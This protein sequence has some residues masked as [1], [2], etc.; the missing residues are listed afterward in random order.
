MHLNLRRFRYVSTRVITAH[1]SALA[2]KIVFFSF[3]LLLIVR[4]FKLLVNVVAWRLGFLLTPDPIQQFIGC[5]NIAIK[6][7]CSHFK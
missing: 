6:V 2:V 4:V 3:F 1:L 7:S 5:I